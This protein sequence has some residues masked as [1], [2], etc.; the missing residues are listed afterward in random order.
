MEIGADEFIP[1][2]CLRR[3]QQ[4]LSRKLSVSRPLVI[5]FASMTRALQTASRRPGAGLRGNFVVGTAIPALTMIAVIRF[6]RKYEEERE[7]ELQ[8]RTQVRLEKKKIGR[9]ME[10]MN[11]FSRRELRKTGRCPFLYGS[12]T[13]KG[14]RA[15]YFQTP[16]L[17]AFRRFFFLGGVKNWEGPLIAN[18]VFG[19]LS[20]IPIYALP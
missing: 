9:I 14:N 16:P 8:K 10:R 6:L 5:H 17:A 1:V 20:F 18:A 13:A 11:L 7:A 12:C 19:L 3:H 4:Q 15:L 2:Q